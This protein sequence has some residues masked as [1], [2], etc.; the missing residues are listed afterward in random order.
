MITIIIT[1]LI[2]IDKVFLWDD[3]KSRAYAELSFRSAVK[4]VRPGHVR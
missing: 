1:V 4:S 2:I 3:Q